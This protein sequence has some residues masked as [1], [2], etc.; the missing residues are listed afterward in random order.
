MSATVT[1][2]PWDVVHDEPDAPDAREHAATAMGAAR[3]AADSESKA[4][5]HAE[6]AGRHAEK[7]G[8]IDQILADVRKLAEETQEAAQLNVRVLEGIA[9]AVAALVEKM[10]TTHHEAM[11]RIGEA[12]EQMSKPR[13]IVRDKDGRAAGVE[14]G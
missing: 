14:V 1:R 12:M 4:K 10:H 13:R 6:T 7:V 11:G 3:H 9:H 2:G 5:E 8:E